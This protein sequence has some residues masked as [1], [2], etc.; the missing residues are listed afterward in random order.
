MTAS[1]AL[2]PEAK[3]LPVD[4]ATQGRE[5]RALVEV[6][7]PSMSPEK[8]SALP[9]A[10]NQAPS[11]CP[12]SG[13]EAGASAPGASHRPASVSW[14]PGSCCQLKPGDTVPASVAGAEVWGRG[15]IPVTPVGTGVTVLPTSPTCSR[16]RHCGLWGTEALSP[17]AGG[18]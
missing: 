16:C 7:A 4:Q 13:R 12:G 17:L 1:T 9:L 6:P 11:R 5:G 14:A 3:A 18:K 2:A 10:W 8:A 15:L